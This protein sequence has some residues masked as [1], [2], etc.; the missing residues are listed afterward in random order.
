MLRMLRKARVLDALISRTKQQILAATLL[1]P[2]R[3]WY[4]LELAR[5][6]RVRPSSLQRELRLLTEA[7]ILK[8]NKNGNRVYF[9]AEPAC[10]IRPELALIL[11]KTVGV[12]DVLK[13]VLAHIQ[14]HIAAAFVYGSVATSSERSTSDI[15]LMVIGATSLSE[16]APIL[17]KAQERLGRA[18]NPTVYSSA[19]FR[20]QIHQ[21]RHFLKTVLRE[22]KLFVI[23]TQ[24]DL[25]KLASSPKDKVAPHQPARAQRSARRH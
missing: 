6:L 2:E 23:G 16:V 13:E 18:V 9:Q 12:A 24:D 17:R 11:A 7:G 3:S 1:Q 22:E 15:D 10:P 4:L 25:A 21:E 8:R 14:D 20:R 19:E 5:H